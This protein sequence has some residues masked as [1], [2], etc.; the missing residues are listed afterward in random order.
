MREF[1][2]LQRYEK[3]I[4]AEFVQLKKHNIT[5]LNYSC[6]GGICLLYENINCLQTLVFPELKTIYFVIVQQMRTQLKTLNI[7][8]VVTFFNCL[9]LVF[10]FKL[11]NIDRIT[12]LSFYFLCY[13]IV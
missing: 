8:R 12:V 1:R 11:N 10:M 2:T 7:D 13:L 6:H 9:L 4:C 3:H 5:V